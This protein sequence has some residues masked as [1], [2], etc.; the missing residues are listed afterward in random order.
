M[1]EAMEVYFTNAKCNYLFPLTVLVNCKEMLILLTFCL[2]SAP[3]I[4]LQCLY[5]IL[6]G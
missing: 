6:P 3:S 1:A 5:K 4:P 2:V